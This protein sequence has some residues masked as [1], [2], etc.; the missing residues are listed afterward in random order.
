MIEE[1]TYSY[2]TTISERIQCWKGLKLESDVY[3]KQWQA[4]KSLLKTTDYTKILQCYELDEKTFGIGLLPFTEERA[5]VLLP[6][7]EKSEW[8]QLHRTLF[9]TEVS[10]KE[11]SLRAALRFHIDYYERHIRNLSKKFSKIRLSEK[12]IVKLIEQLS[13]EFLFI[14]QKTLVWDVHQ[15]IEE[16]HLQA[17][18]KEEEFIKYIDEFL[19]DKQRTYLFY[20]E[21]PALARVL[22]TR[23]GFACEMIEEFISAVNDSTEQIAKMFALVSPMDITKIEVGKGDSHDHGKTV[24]QFQIQE[25]SLIFKFKNLE[26]GERFNALLTYLEGLDPTLS[27]Y[28][29]KRIVQPTFT[30]EER[31][32]H[33]ECRDEDEVTKFYQEYGQLLAIVYWLGSTDLHMENVIASG[34]H[35]VL[36]DVETLIRPEMFKQTKKPSRQIRIEKQSVLVTGLVPQKK[37]WKRVLEMDALSGTEQKLPKKFEG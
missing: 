19:G 1:L 24:I 23:L 25:K 5:Q 4:R 7:V 28:K 20:G 27:F 10:I 16:Y 36:I 9:R 37:Q 12:T 13:D 15:M 30:I 11:K 6:T 2:A 17:E 3:F 22:A 31:V 26:I 8:F 29:I 32:A 35:P 33:Q 18:T 14:A 21:Y 34:A